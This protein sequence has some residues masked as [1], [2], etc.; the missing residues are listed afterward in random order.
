MSLRL[1]SLKI[2]PLARPLAL[3]PFAS[4]F[5]VIRSNKI[6]NREDAKKTRKLKRSLIFSYERFEY[7]LQNC[8]NLQF[9]WRIGTFH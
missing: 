8:E 3:I 7:A 9:I 2:A 5:K 6:V 1:I 4:L